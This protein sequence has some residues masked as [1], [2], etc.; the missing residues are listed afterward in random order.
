M[1]HFI[2]TQIQFAKESWLRGLK[3]VTPEDAKKRFGESNCISWMVGHMAQFD[4]M[5]WLDTPVADL[6][7]FAWGRPAST[8]E[9]SDVL[10][11]WH[12]VNIEVNHVL[13]T[14]TEADMQRPSRFTEE[15]CATMLQRQTWHYWYHLGEMQAIRQM[16]GHQGLPQYVGR[17]G[18]TVYYP[19]Q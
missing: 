10:D 19:N 3:D 2:V 16:M 5:A 14:F 11:A 17:M 12:T 18:S 15:N 9:L 13:N 7:T 6:E 1:A 4:Q 8:P